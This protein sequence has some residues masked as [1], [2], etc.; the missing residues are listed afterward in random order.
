LKLEVVS[1]KHA[2]QILFFNGGARDF[3]TS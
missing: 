1:G 2:E 3:D